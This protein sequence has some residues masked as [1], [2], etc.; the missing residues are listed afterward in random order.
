MVRMVK[1]ETFDLRRSLRDRQM[2]RFKNC[3]LVYVQSGS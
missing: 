2:E 3:E 1:V